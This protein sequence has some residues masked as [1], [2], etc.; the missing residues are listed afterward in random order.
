M[1]RP[2]TNNVNEERCG[3]G[4]LSVALGERSILGG[5]ISSMPTADAIRLSSIEPVVARRGIFGM[6]G[7]LK[8]L[9]HASPRGARRARSGASAGADADATRSAE[10][11][12]S[13]AT[14]DGR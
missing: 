3:P 1:C 14:F 8:G 6:V 10:C 13:T 7:V 4:G 9:P 5:T 2:W 12:R 11:L